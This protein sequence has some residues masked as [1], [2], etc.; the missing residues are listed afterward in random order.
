MIQI[1]RLI[2]I[3]ISLIIWELLEFLLFFL[4]KEFLSYKINFSS[5]MLISIYTLYIL[6]NIFF[7]PLQLVIFFFYDD[8]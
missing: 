4:K 7:S 1:N 3:W 5:T 8:N 6:K 2:N